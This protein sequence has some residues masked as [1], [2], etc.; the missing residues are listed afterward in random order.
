M[1]AG[2]RVRAAW[3]ARWPQGEFDL[4][5]ELAAPIPI[6][7]LGEILG[8]PDEE[9]PRLIELGDRLLVDTDPEYVG[10][11]AYEGEREEDR[12]K[13]FGSPWAEELCALGPRPLRRA[14]RMPARRRAH[15]DRHRRDR[16]RSRCRRAS[17]TTCS[18]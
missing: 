2:A 10:E 3:T 17:W 13:P 5:H 9:L 15:P 1:A 11:L 18:R 6:R 4:V 8:L 14:A 16:R 12:Y 7:V